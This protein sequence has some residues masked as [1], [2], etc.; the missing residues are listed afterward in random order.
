M[1]FGGASMPEVEST[2]EKQSTK[3]LSAGAKAAAEAQKEKTKKNR[4]LAAS[5]MTN[6]TGMASS[7]EGQG[8]KTLG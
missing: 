5:I 3:S 2:P 6:R 1:S 4:G 7:S 8:N